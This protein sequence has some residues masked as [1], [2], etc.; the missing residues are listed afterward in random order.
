[1]EQIWKIG[2]LSLLVLAGVGLVVA[3]SGQAANKVAKQNS[4]SDGVTDICPGGCGKAAGSCGPDCTCGCQGGKC[5]GGCGEAAGS[6]GPDCDCGCQNGSCNG[7]CG[8][9]SCGGGCGCGCGG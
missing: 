3:Y 5:A 6:C 9:K 7:G 4:V 2:F 8:Q 1:M